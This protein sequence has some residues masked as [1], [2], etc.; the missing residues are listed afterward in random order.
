MWDNK[1]LQMDLV[2]DIVDTFVLDR[3]YSTLLPSNTT[4]TDVEY[5]QNIA[6][7][8]DMPPSEWAGKSLVARDNPFRQGITLFILT[9]YTTALHQLYTN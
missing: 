1:V 7:Y 8:I 5:N 4:S 9:W 6:Q 2:L 3:V